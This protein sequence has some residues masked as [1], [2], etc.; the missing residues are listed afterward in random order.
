M[1]SL[2]ALIQPEYLLV[3]K[4]PIKTAHMCNEKLLRVAH[5]KEEYAMDCNILANNARV[6]SYGFLDSCRTLWEARRLLCGT[7]YIEN[8]LETKEKH[9]LSHPFCQEII[10]EEFYGS[11]DTKRFSTKVRYIAKF[12]TAWLRAP[13]F[14]LLLIKDSL[15]RRNWTYKYSR[16]DYFCKELITPFYSFLADVINYALL[17]IFLIWTSLTIRLDTTHTCEDINIQE[18]STKYS[19]IGLPELIL[20]LCLLSRIQTEI[21]QIYFRGPKVAT[22]LFSAKFPF[23]S[24]AANR[25][26]FKLKFY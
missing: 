13:I 15:I 1:M 17:L 19:K 3:T 24:I 4:D 23:L 12:F 6:F 26:Y 7:N 25:N 20:W 16:L 18:M 22:L 5:K 2:T 21:Y 8:A 9:F 14:L 10:L 11:K